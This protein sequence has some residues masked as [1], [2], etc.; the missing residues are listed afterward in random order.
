M[1]VDSFLRRWIVANSVAE[2]VG[3]GT[4][5]VIGAAVAPHLGNQDSLATVLLTALIAVLAGAFLEGAVVG[6]AQEQIIR[7]RVA[8]MRPGIWTLATVAGAGLAWLLGMLPS[9][10]MAIV[11]PAAPTTGPAAAPFEPDPLVVYGLAAG[12]GLVVGPILGLAQWFVL[13]RVVPGSAAWLWANARAWAVGMPAIFAGMD[14]VPW[15][16]PS[17]ARIIAIYAVCGVAGA[18]V[19]AIHG[20]V[21]RRLLRTSDTTI[22]GGFDSR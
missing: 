2:A 18:I 19:G 13:R 16:G 1:A 15:N 5:F 4:T 12:L 17:A 7:S 9:S 10:I 3:L 8:L 11:A 21:L 14:L 6:F 20:P 22:E